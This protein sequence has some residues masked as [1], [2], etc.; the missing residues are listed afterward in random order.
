[1]STYSKPTTKPSHYN[2]K[3][4]PFDSIYEQ[5]QAGLTQR[6]SS[7]ITSY[8]PSFKHT[9]PNRLQIFFSQFS[10]SHYEICFRQSYYEF[11]LH[12][13]ST[14][15]LNMERRQPFDTNLEE[16]SKMVGLLVRSGP[17]ENKGRMRV[18]YERKHE[19]I[20]QGRII[21][22]I[23]QYSNFIAATF[24]ILLNVYQNL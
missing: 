16:L 7:G 11:A 1:M 2:D 5:I 14:P 12:F 23:D 21:Q 4:Q 10:G 19:P 24:P 9:A 3:N 15:P 17:L 18:W 13:E 6:F 8:N 22:Y 20:D